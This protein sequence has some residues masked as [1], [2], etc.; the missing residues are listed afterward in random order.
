MLQ[1]RAMNHSE[2]LVRAVWGHQTSSG[3]A[4]APSAAPQQ[5]GNRGCLLQQHGHCRERQKHDSLFGLCDHGE[6]LLP[7]HTVPGKQTQFTKVFL[8][9]LNKK[10]NDKI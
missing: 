4:A 9:F 8:F 5:F 10:S 7:Y 2:L 6:S 3:K 1:N